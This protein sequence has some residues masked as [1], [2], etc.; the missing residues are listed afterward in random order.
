MTPRLSDSALYKLCQDGKLSDLRGGYVDDLL[1]TDCDT[2]RT[3]TRK[4]HKRFEMGEGNTNDFISLCSARGLPR[5][6][7]FGYYNGSNNLAD[8]LTSPIC[9][10]SLR[11]VLFSGLLSVTLEQCNI[12]NKTIMVFTCPR[13]YFLLYILTH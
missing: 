7:M 10:A 5:L 4:T 8:G 12:R 9:Q 11:S 1:W 6:S 3:L 2:F 13:L